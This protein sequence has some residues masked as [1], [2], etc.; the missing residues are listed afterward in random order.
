MKKYNKY[1]WLAICSVVVLA[2]C[3][4]VNCTKELRKSPSNEKAYP[5]QVI[6]NEIRY[7]D[8]VLY[9]FIPV[10]GGLMDF[11]Y[12]TDSLTITEAA[13]Q[14]ED[15]ELL[16][17]TKRKEIPSFIIGETPV[18]VKLWDV[19]M[20]ESLSH[21]VDQNFTTYINNKT[22]EEWFSFLKKL[23]EKT[24]RKFCLPTSFEWEYAARGGQLSKN[25]VYAGGNNINEVANYKDNYKFQTFILGKCKRSNE[26]GLYD[27]SGGVMELTTTKCSE[28]NFGV[29][30]EL[31]EEKGGDAY[32]SRGGDFESPA[33][34]CEIKR[35]RHGQRV[36]TGA[37]IILKY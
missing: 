21:V 33:E 12:N 29:F 24:G 7:N 26:L 25:F 10:D 20:E 14:I 6:D 30:K 32:I 16:F 9:R 34:E 5:L 13:T 15:K 28:L 17:L 22:H 2:L 11:T 27:M 35:V 37:R 18:T 1:E 4:I 8:Q 36:R 19:V 31:I 23:E 3:F